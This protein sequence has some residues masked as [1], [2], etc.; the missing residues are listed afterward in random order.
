M[1]TSFFHISRPVPGYGTGLALSASRV[2]DSRKSK[3]KRAIVEEMIGTRILLAVPI[4]VDGE[5][6]SESDD[7]F[8]IV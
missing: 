8:V 5:N 3:T 7:G 1:L 2:A 6:D 4:R